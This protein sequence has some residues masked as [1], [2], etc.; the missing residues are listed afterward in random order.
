MTTPANTANVPFA[1]IT[2]GLG[3]SHG[4][5]YRELAAQAVEKAYANTIAMP[6]IIPLFSNLTMT[7]ARLAAAGILLPAPMSLQAI[8]LQAQTLPATTGSFVWNFRNIPAGSNASNNMFSSNQTFARRINGNNA[9]FD[10]LGTGVTFTDLSSSFNGGGGTLTVSAMTSSSFLYLGCATPFSGVF[11]T[12]GS[13]NSNAS[14]LGGNYWNGAWSA[15]TVTDGTASAGA[16]LAQNGEATW[17][18]P[19]DWQRTTVNGVLQYWV[20]L[21]VTATLSNPTTATALSQ[22]R[23]PGY[24]YQFIPNQN[25]AGLMNDAVEFD[26]ITADA[27]AVNVS[28]YSIWKP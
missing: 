24:V 5:T 20:Q 11:F 28:A 15:L 18:T 4:I 17:T 19:N 8:Y 12:A 21:T 6:F 27:T 7:P 23:S 14:V 1:Q 3:S 10:L 25:Q 9:F 16:T 2:P 22:V 26:I 13:A